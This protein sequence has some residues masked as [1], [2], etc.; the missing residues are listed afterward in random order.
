MRKKLAGTKTS[1][2][3]ALE[4]LRRIGGVRNFV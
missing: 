2:P 1:V 4:T 3:A